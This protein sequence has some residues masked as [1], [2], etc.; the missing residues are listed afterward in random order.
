VL[1]FSKSEVDGAIYK[2]K[3]KHKEE[4]FGDQGLLRLVHF[5]FSSLL[6]KQSPHAY[7]AIELLVTE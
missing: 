2:E 3:N 7:L 6:E 1:G 4:H 5:P